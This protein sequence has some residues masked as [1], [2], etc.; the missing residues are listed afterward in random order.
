MFEYF[1]S[2]QP[3][4]PIIG[5]VIGAS[6]A[7]FVGYFFLQKRKQVLFFVEGTEDI[8]SPLRRQHGLISFKFGLRDVSNLCRS[9]VRVRNN[10]NSAIQNFTFEIDIPGS[11]PFHLDEVVCSESSLYKAITTEWV[12][13][14]NFLR[15]KISVPF[16]NPKEH[17][18]TKILFDGE[19]DDLWIE[20][21]MEDLKCKVKRPFNLEGETFS[22]AF[23]RGVIKGLGGY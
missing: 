15:L 19:P 23:V 22:A 9:A 2:L 18:E 13:L 4:A 3:I 1:V 12:V 5:A 21:R 6:I 20:C 17:F 11:H 16:F 8:T 7:A 10:G 14:D